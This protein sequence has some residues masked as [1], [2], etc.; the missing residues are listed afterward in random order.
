M[1]GENFKGHDG[2]SARDRRTAI[3]GA[4]MVDKV[5]DWLASLDADLP[6]IADRFVF[7]EIWGR[8]GLAHEER[9]LIAIAHLSA[10]RHMPQLRS[11]LRGALNYGIKTRKLH[12]TLMM[13]HVYCGFAVAQES[14]LAWKDVLK[15]AGR[16][17]GDDD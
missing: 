7:A 5:E 8:I 11:Y 6:A 16:T 13:L 12:E 17:L 4:D 15:E 1:A 9:V 2:V 3:Q 14:L 10:T